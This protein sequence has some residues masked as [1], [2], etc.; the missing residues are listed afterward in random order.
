MKTDIA[1][2][3]GLRE[4]LT[5]SNRHSRMNLGFAF[6]IGIYF[7]LWIAYALSAFT[8]LGGAS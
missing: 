7:G 6:V 1:Y 2:L 3:C 5:L 8:L 4:G